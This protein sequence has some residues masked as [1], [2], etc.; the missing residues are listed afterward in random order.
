MR[1]CPEPGCYTQVV[2]GRCPAHQRAARQARPDDRRYTRLGNSRRWR[3][4]SARFL[5]THPLCVA[6]KTAGRVVAATETHHRV[7]HRGDPATFWDRS[8]WTPL[9]HACHSRAT[10]YE[11]LHQ[12]GPT[13]RPA[14]PLTGAERS[15]AELARWG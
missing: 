1:L 11:T 13:S 2:T 6:C 15:L 12:G 7:P 14:R 4:E 8:L 9:C 3:R 10:A 5:Q